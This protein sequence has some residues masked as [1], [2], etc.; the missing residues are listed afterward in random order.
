MSEISDISKYQRRP[1]SSR[2]KPKPYPLER[3]VIRRYG[4]STVA[5][6]YNPEEPPAS[7]T[8]INEYKKSKKFGN[9]FGRIIDTLKELS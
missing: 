3:T 1:D 9:M 7:V 5:I 8:D 4:E 2:L 6:A